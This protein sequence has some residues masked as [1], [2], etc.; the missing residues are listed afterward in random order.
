[1]E[2]KI[3]Q[4]ILT[5]IM[6]ISFV[7]SMLVNDV[8]ADSWS[9]PILWID[10]YDDP[11]ASL[12]ITL[13]PDGSL[14]LMD[15]VC[16][17]KTDGVCNTIQ[18]E[19]T[20]TPTPLGDD[21]PDQQDVFLI[22]NSS[23][24]PQPQATPACSGHTLL[25]DGRF[26]T[27]GGFDWDVW[28][29]EGKGLKWATIYDGSTW[30]HVPEPMAV[31]RW[32]P[33]ATR[34]ADSR[35]LV[36]SGFVMFQPEQWQNLALETYDPFLGT[37]EL[38]STFPGFPIQSPSLPD[39]PPEIFNED[40]T[41]VFQLPNS[42][43]GH[44]VL[45]IGELGIPVLLSTFQ[46]SWTVIDNPRP[47]DPGETPFVPNS[48]SSSLLLP[49]RINDG[50]WGYSN[51]S[52]LTAGGGGDGESSKYHADVYDPVNNVWKEGTDR[53]NL[54][55]PR[56]HPSTVLLPDGKILIVAGHSQGTD[57]NLLG[58]A[59]YIDPAN[60]FAVSSGQSNY[61]EVRG[62]HTVTVLLPDGRVLVG[63]GTIFPISYSER[64]D[65]RYYSPDYISGTRSTI[66]G[67]PTNLQYGSS[68]TVTWNS[69]VPIDEVVLIALG[70]MT[71]SFDM[72]QRYVQLEVL[73]TDAAAG[74]TT[75][76]APP[77]AMVAPAGHYMLFILDQNR[78]PSVA[79]IVMVGDIDNDGVPDDQDN[80]PNTPN[81][82]QI[83]SDGD[84]TGDACD[85]ATIALITL[86][87]PSSDITTTT[88]TFDWLAKPG[89]NVSKY[90][91]TVGTTKYN[92]WGDI[93]WKKMN[94]NKTS[95]KVK[96][97]PMYV[98]KIYV[99]LG[100]RINDQWHWSAFE[101]YLIDSLAEK[102][103]MGAVGPFTAGE[104]DVAFN[105][106][107]GTDVVAYGITVTSNILALN[108]PGW[109]TPAH[110]YNNE[111]AEPPTVLSVNEVD[112]LLLDQNDDPLTTIYVRL[113]S[114]FNGSTTWAYNDYTYNVM[115]P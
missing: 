90:W 51:G 46:E 108:Y 4:L 80:C 106:S 98:D 52:I 40:Y 29:E 14:V 13:M 75:F 86:P 8:R 85:P 23:L 37:W 19:F 72:N 45:M 78:I 5:M 113:W 56:H 111:W 32:Y 59:Q 15:V 62:Y 43:N 25:S 24:Y 6:L 33:T 84:D 101:E 53:I 58:T 95:R 49:I 76:R 7:L 66:L 35:I 9:N 50:E 26:F 87:D 93:L 36:T 89:I 18:G 42:I 99:R 48:G 100:S 92:G 12:H 17:E 79:E 61:T 21:I 63:S 68:Y 10:Q 103:V 83:N 31:E 107:A 77:T 82:D 16:D 22:D 28:P 34:L 94:S 73:S 55:V 67:V 47:F 3:R 88:V 71:H 20:M 114:K 57:P 65:F 112:L 110:I 27:V 69:T 104:Q 96:N 41:H 91:L 39:T 81:V 64:S 97:I 102:A 115:Q 109:N 2:R 30:T 44:D 11:H 70:S 74:T 54:T 1:M 60:G 38:I 105:W